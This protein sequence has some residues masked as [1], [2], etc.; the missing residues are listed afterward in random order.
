MIQSNPPVTHWCSNLNLAGKRPVRTKLPLPQIQ[1]LRK[2]PV[3][4]PAG[5]ICDSQNGLGEH[6]Q[7]FNR[8]FSS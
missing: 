2:K 1:Y 8:F 5:H 4:Y 6:L 3:F 7:A